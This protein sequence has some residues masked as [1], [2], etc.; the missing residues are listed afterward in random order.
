[1]LNIVEKNRYLQCDMMN[2]SQHY[3]VKIN[4]IVKKIEKYI[5]NQTV[6]IKTIQLHDGIEEDV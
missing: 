6:S 3:H 1:M 5:Q 2:L 4:C